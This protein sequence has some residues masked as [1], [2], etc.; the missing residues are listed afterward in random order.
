MTILRD[1]VLSSYPDYPR[2]KDFNLGTNCVSSHFLS[3]MGK[4]TTDVLKKIIVQASLEAAPGVERMVDVCRV[5]VA[6]DFDLHWRLAGRQ[7]KNLMLDKLYEGVLPACAEYGID[8]RPVTEAYGRLA[9]TDL[10][11]VRQWGRSLKS[12]DGSKIARVK[13]YYDLDAV[14]IVVA[15][16]PRGRE[17]LAK[18]VPLASTAPHE[19]RFVPLLGKLVWKDEKTVA[20]LPKKSGLPEL[21]ATVG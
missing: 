1:L 18:E 12:P 4:I 16:W 5:E 7:R 15:T 13:Y 19:W 9:G 14:K 21:S 8:P 10:E 2:R 3:E 17:H 11:Y 6:Y 20:L